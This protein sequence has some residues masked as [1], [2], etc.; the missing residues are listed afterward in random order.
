MPRIYPELRREKDRL[1][2]QAQQLA[3]DKS[4]LHDVQ[5]ALN[6]LAQDVI[7]VSGR[8]GQFATLWAVVRR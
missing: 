4:H 7:D 5:N 3:K 6:I 2:A 1:A 8:L